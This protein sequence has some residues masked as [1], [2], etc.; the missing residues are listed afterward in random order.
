MV[1]KQRADKL[2][3]YIP[4]LETERQ[5]IDRL[6]QLGQEK[7]RSISTLVVEAV[8]EYLDRKEARG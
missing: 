3:V 8:L 1:Q 7:D 4:D 6:I 2:N 5:P